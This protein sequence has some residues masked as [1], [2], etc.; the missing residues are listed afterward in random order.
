MSKRSQQIDTVFRQG[1]QLHRIGRLAEAE[2]IYRQV[3]A[4]MPRHADALHALGAL[5]LQAGRPAV[6]ETLLDQ[7]IGLKPA[8]DFQVTRAHTLLALNRPL[9]A[10]AA[11]RPVL[12]ARPH[13]AEAHQVLGHAL[14]DADQPGNAIDAYQ[15]ALRLKP[16]LPD[17]LNN[18][19]MALRQ[20][21]R[22]EEAEQTL[23]QAP[24]EPESLVNLSS[25]QKE[26]GAF[27]DAE[28]TLHQALRLAPDSPV[29]RY[30]W[31]LLM[32]LLGR[33]PEA[34]DGWEQRFRAGAIPPRAFSQPQWQG[35]P[36]GH[37]RLL[38]HTEQGL[39]DVIQ[40]VRYLPSIEGNIL[41]EAPPRLI[42]L[43][44]SNPALP[45]MIPDG[46]PPPTIDTVV[47]LLS[48][49]ARTHLPAAQP[50]YLFA[51]PDR[52]AHWR[53]RIGAGGLRIGINWQGFPGR[54][55]DK[56]RSFPLALF[57]PL[58]AVPN[59]RLI[60][61][62]KGEAEAQIVAAGF[63]VETLDGLDSGPDAF[64]DTAAV[65]A[66]LDLI[67][68]SDTSI[69][70]LA[71]ALGRP[72]WVALRFVP[73]W[74]WMLDRADSPWY[75]TMRLFRQSRHGDWAP[76]FAAMAQALPR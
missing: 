12:R 58:A 46:A 20:A 45:P 41:F 55:E 50:P 44:S 39:G 24:P 59:V 7:A 18:L 6:A 28:A 65:M 63:P 47:S 76:V 66:S 31:S 38:V 56:G 69:A 36:L 30:N 2:Q 21:N 35:D 11:I 71:G 23:R 16:A 57:E 64:L 54:F 70:H 19:G 26:R 52:V 74:R 53:G 8:A 72:V 60:S 48:L 33:T 22:L 29:L 43:L 75:P 14:S 4:A 62:Q 1:Q 9:D 3:I 32:H 68:T 27:A 49:P 10:A 67:V 40:F 61:L 5:A 51:E 34:W 13:S 73:D 15:A 42:R 17:V 37:R 25:V